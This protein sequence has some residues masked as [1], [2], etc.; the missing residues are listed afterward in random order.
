L[1]YRKG[2]ED[3]IRAIPLVRE[4]YPRVHLLIAGEGDHRQPLNQLISETNTTHSVTLLGARNDVPTLLKLADLFVFPS[5]YEGHGGAL[6]EAMFAG[7]PIIAADTEVHRESITHHETGFLVPMKC[8][9]RLAEGIIWMLE[10]PDKGIEMGNRAQ[11][12]AVRKFS[13]GLVAEK[14]EQL[15]SEIYR[16]SLASEL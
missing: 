16:H 8:P 15:Y 3:L 9:E 10:N 12:T 2:Q 14:H 1:L 13:I 4:K 5:H 7:C 11:A 6:V